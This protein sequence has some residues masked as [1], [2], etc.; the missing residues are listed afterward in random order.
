MEL[1]VATLNVWALPASIA[2]RVPD[3]MR[4]I[5]RN[6]RTLDLDIVAFQEVWT[7]SART[8]L[9]AAGRRAGLDHFWHNEL[10]LRG[11]GLLVLS[12]LPIRSIR[13]ERFA[14]RGAPQGFTH[15]DFIKEVKMRGS[16]FRNFENDSK[17]KKGLSQVF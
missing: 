10:S 2:E 4:A 11:S 1:C 16:V 13:F 7:E 12:R 15:I 5:G 9:I 6:L 14:I 8:A 3:R 17:R